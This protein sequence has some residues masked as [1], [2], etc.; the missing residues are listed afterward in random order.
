MVRSLDEGTFG[1]VWE[2]LDQKADEKKCT[3][4]R[5]AIKL[6]KPSSVVLEQSEFEL[7]ILQSLQPIADQGHM[8]RLLDHFMYKEKTPCYVF[9]Y[10][11]TSLASVLSPKT[12]T[13]ETKPIPINLIVSF[14]HQILLALLYLGVQPRGGVIHG[15]LKPG[16]IMIGPST[17]ETDPTDQI[18][19]IDFGSSHWGDGGR[20][21][22]YQSR[23]YRS[24]D[25]I[26]G[27][28]YGCGI[29][30]WSLGCVVMEMITGQVLFPGDHE[31]EMIERQV[32][33]LGLPSAHVINSG[34]FS[35]KYFNLSQTGLPLEASKSSPNTL[36]TLIYEHL[37][38]LGQIEKIHLLSLV[39]SMLEWDDQIRIKP[40]N[41]LC[42]PLFT[43]YVETNKRFDFNLL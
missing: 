34:R 36:H 33:I 38:A 31:T 11:P 19:L 8:V 4:A 43:Y 16:N 28:R 17:S 25:I 29:D 41:A 35:S 3:P 6:L 32:A 23:W 20:Y 12:K 10:F 21:D 40:L 1:R 39:S 22:Y 26:L 30:M 15:D 7:E 13:S 14:T 24:P 27:R 18:K 2:C 9:E 37:P 42:H 5:V